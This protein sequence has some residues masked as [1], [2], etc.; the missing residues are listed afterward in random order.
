VTG[1]GVLVR[2]ELLEQWR[3]LRLPVV[4]VVFLLV[5][6]GSPLLA[7]FTPE[8]LD[9]LAPSEIPIPIPPPTAADAVDQLLRNLMQFGGLAAILLAMG[10]VASEKE[11]GTA[12][13]LMT[14]PASRAAFLATK[15][16]AIG[17]TLA[18]GVGIAAIAA[19]VYTALLF[20]PL[21]L[22]GFAA[23]GALGWLILAS[24]A[25]L[26]FLASTLLGSA[27]AAGGLGF[28]L[29]LGLSILSSLPRVGELLPP[30]LVAPARAIA[31]G[32]PAG[33]LLGPVAASVALIALCLAAALAAFRRQEL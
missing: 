24:F 7:R 32:Q 12:A 19:W 21:P 17:L 8:L 1:F 2:K 18:V 20:E 30:G 23:A 31:T 4:A 25:A 3:T 13:L 5:G 6:L 33:D 26:T 9:A 11:R 22:G 15:A 16:V 29:F 28:G 27:A 14:T 10:A